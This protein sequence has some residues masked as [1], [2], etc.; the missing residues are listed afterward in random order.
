[1]DQYLGNY[2]EEND[3]LPPL[4]DSPKDS[5]NLSN[6]N[7]EQTVVEESQTD[8]SIPQAS[9]NISSNHLVAVNYH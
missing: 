3:R 9:N 5:A 2:E 4:Q 7:S 1:M 6:Y 8:S